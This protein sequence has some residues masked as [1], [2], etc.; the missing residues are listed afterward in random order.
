MALRTLKSSLVYAAVG[1]SIGFGVGVVRSTSGGGRAEAAS[2]ASDYA[3][4]SADADALASCEDL[5]VL[6]HES[7][8]AFDT[9]VA[10]LDKLLAVRAAAA[11]TSRPVRLSHPA[12]AHRHL[13]K[14]VDALRVMQDG[15]EDADAEAALATVQKLMDDAVFNVTMDTRARLDA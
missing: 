15:C 3:H 6:R 11:D 2:W 14:A 9:F 12:A 4:L 7:P 1:A 13:R 10:H 8:D 5:L